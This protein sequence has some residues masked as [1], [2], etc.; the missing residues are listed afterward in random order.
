MDH[1]RAL[2]Q[3]HCPGVAV[4]AIEIRGNLTDNL[5]GYYFKPTSHVTRIPNLNTLERMA[6][7][8]GCTRAELFEAFAADLG[9]VEARDGAQEE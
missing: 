1:L 6:A 5:I 2:L 3:H 9:Y 7:A 8:I 4:R